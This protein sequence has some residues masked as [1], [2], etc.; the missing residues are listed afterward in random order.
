VLSVQKKEKTTL[1]G[2]VVL[3]VLNSAL[4]GIAARSICVNLFRKVLLLNFILGKACLDTS[5]TV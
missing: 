1:S 3:F 4:L 2:I 5:L